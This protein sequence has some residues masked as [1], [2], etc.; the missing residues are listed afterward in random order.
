MTWNILHGG[1]ATRMPLI[2]LALL[3]QG[4]DVIALTE[5]RSTIGGQIQGVLADHGYEHQL[6]T[7]LSRKRNGILLASRF[8]LEP[9]ETAVPQDLWC[10]RWLEASVPAFSMRL[11]VVHVPDDSMVRARAE[12]WQHLV[13]YGR[14]HRRTRSVVMGDFNTGR[15][16]VDARG[17]CFACE[18]LLGTFCAIGYRDAF[19][20]KH[21]GAREYSWESHFGGGFRIDGAFVSPLLWSHVQEAGYSH[22]ERV[23]RTSDH[24]LFRMSLSIE[25]REGR[26]SP[27]NKALFD[28]Q[29][30][31]NGANH[32]VFEPSVEKNAENGRNLIGNHGPVESGRLQSEIRGGTTTFVLREK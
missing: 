20:L 18:R 9:L 1:G 2:T 26:K 8:P 29:G 17:S 32:E 23:E 10:N 4:A 21:P 7:R 16:Y 24:S 3:E 28:G 22:E 14:R 5:F 11:A 12:Y 27:G 13:A 30:R 19:R 31:K 15:R 25:A 6:T